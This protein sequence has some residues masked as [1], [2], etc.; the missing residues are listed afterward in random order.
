MPH[1][2][3]HT[4][5]LIMIIMSHMLLFGLCESAVACHER[6]N[7]HV[8]MQIVHLGS[9]SSEEAAMRTYDRVRDRPLPLNTQAIANCMLQPAYLPCPYVTRA[10]I[11]ALLHLK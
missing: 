5:C 1:V 6:T 11:D 9:H 3:M 2:Y 4:H 7:M 8:A 10:S